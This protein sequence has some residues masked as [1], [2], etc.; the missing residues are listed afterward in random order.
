M[1][2]PTIFWDLDDTLI[3][4]HVHYAQALSEFGTYTHKR[5]GVNARL[6]EE[7]VSK[8]DR[9]AVRLHPGFDKWRFP[10]SFKAA[11][12]ALDV[13]ENHPLDLLAAQQSFNIGAQIL[14]IGAG[15]TQSAYKLR[16]GAR[17]I[18]RHYT[19]WQQVLYTLGDP[20]VQEAKIQLHG[21]REIFG[22]N[23]F[24]VSEKSIQQLKTVVDATGAE[25]RASWLIGDS[26]HHDIKP[27]GYVGLRTIHIQHA[28][29]IF[30]TIPTAKVVRD[31]QS[32]TH[33][34]PNDPSI[35]DEPFLEVRG[36]C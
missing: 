11:S 3:E 23:V 12:L 31:F 29:G 10:R 5:L 36:G 25:I 2:R 6:A 9:D 34:I 20:E 28:P 30:D 16:P 8:L 1:S 26:L 17:E 4:C 32:I 21:L 35:R 24:V 7:F 19:N 13:L 22:S 27:A 33:L 14:N 18:L 15:I